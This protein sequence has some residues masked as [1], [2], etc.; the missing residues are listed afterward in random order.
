MDNER[1]HRITANV[2]SVQQRIVQSAI[3]SGR[4]DNDVRLIA[5][6]KYTEIGD[7]V[8]EALVAAGCSDLGEARPQRLLEK[9]EHSAATPGLV[10]IRWHLIGALQRNKVRK[11]LS[12]LTLIHSLDSLR[13]AEAIDRIAAEEQLPPIHCLLEVAL[14]KDMEKQGIPPEQVLKTLD[15]MG[16]YH[17]IVVDGLMGMAGLESDEPQIHREFEL[18]RK[19]AESARERKLPPNVPLAELS[20]GMSDDFEIAIEEGATLVRIGSILYR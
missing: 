3:K 11:I 9:A 16:T 2:Q 12:V 7:G 13:L 4:A 15:E 14:S 1:Q 5:V 20:M 10:P 19:T 17:N 8:V 6:T 18:L